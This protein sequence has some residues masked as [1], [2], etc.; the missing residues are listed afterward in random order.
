MIEQSLERIAVALER[1][2]GM[3]RVDKTPEQ[4]PPPP[5]PP[6][7]G[8]PLGPIPGT[9]IEGLVPRASEDHRAVLKKQLRAKGIQFP[10]QARTATLEKMLLDASKVEAPAAPAAPSINRDTVKEALISLSTAKSKELAMKIL[11]AI[12]GAGKLSEVP[13]AHYAAIVEAC[14]KEEGNG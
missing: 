10:E 13:E 9:P 11:K 12:G 7:R 5:P 8:A 3:E 6:S 2:A 14:K 4:E 1:I